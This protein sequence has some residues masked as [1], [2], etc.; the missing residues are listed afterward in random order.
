M[1]DKHYDIS[2]DFDSGDIQAF[3][4]KLKQ[5]KSRNWI[6]WLKANLKF[7]FQ[8]ERME[9]DLDSFAP[10]DVQARNTFPVG[11]KVEVLGIAHE[12]CDVEFEGVIVEVK[13]KKGKGYLPLQDLEVRPKS[14]PD[15]WPVREFVVW[16]ANQ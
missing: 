8:A 14:D 6:A 5:W 1:I 2:W 4:R 16:Y 15:Y 11:C 13:G 3:E 9:D 12:D 7:P 10:D